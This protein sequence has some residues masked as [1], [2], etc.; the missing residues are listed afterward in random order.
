MR[1]RKIET[2][3]MKKRAIYFGILIIS[4]AAIV[5]T[6]SFLAYFILDDFYDQRHVVLDRLNQKDL[7]T[8]ALE[9]SDPVYGWDSHGPKVAHDTTCVGST[10][11]YSYDVL[12]AR[13]YSGYRPKD[14]RIIVFGDSYTVGAEANDDDVYP[15]HLASL[16]GTS[17]A[18]HG[19]GGYG[20]VLSFLNFQDKVGL[21]PNARIAI[22]GV[23]YENIYRMMNS[24]WPVLYDTFDYGLKPHMSNGVITG[25]PGSEVFRDIKTFRTRAEIAYDEDFWAKPKFQFPWTFSLYRAIETNYFYFKV[26]QKNLRNI[27]I[28]EYTLAY[29][30]EIITRNL[31]SILNKFAQLSISNNLVPLVI[32]IP[33]NAYDTNSASEF[34]EKY[35][36]QLDNKLG[37]V[38]VGRGLLDWDKYNIRTDD[39]T[40]I[41]HPSA[42]G[43]REIAKYM[44]EYLLGRSIWPLSE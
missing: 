31:I 35:G 21:Y 14:V 6:I 11:T 36:F 26:F 41:C 42:Y 12:G 27:G 17:I 19:V 2:Y 16:L 29:K 20:P 30:S 15:A 13:L 28:P 38:D 43:Y 44:A 39:S 10:V 33:R 7:E 25:F 4:S 9:H 34:L 18:N 37:V 1:A 8:F 22:L 24:Y 5:E 40:N 23:M 32:F 3:K